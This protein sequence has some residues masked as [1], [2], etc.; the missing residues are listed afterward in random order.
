[1]SN[2]IQLKRSS[3]PAAKPT[4]AVLSDGEMAVNLA[5]AILYIKNASGNVIE[6]AGS[7]FAR[8][9][10]PVFQGTPTAPTPV[11]GDNSTK[12]STTAFVKT[13]VDNA[14]AGLD[15]QR[16][17][18]DIQIDNALDPSTSSTGDRYLITDSSNLHANFGTITGLEDG[19]IIEYDGAEFQIVYDVSSSG[20]GVL[21]WDR[22]S[23]SWQ[24]FDGVSWDRFGGLSGVVGGAGIEVNGDTVSLD[25]DDVTIHNNASG[26][27]AIKSSSTA[28]QSMVSKGSG[29]AEWGAVELENQNAISGLLP[30]N[31]GGVG[32][33]LTSFN[34]GNMLRINAAKNGVEAAQEGVDF[35]G[36]NSPVDGGTF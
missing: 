20:E 10:D 28:G 21:V 12:I 24:R 25:A 34:A 32:T 1:M 31:R 29:D 8:L 13:A 9:L 35:L 4:P 14:I 18:L 30:L 33:N 19:D 11:N 26:K 6:I 36:N 2:I 3:T 16:D 23:N 27:A 7:N 5:D 22:T 15:F 17:V